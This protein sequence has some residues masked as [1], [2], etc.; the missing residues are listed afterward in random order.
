MYFESLNVAAAWLGAWEVVS[1]LDLQR[2]TEVRRTGGRERQLRGQSRVW[3]GR[4]FIRSM[5]LMSRPSQWS[6]RS[7]G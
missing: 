7:N 4:V 3:V 2:K 1:G 5:F 6:S